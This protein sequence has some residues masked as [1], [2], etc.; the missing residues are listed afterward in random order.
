MREPTG[1][2]DGV[3]QAGDAAACERIARDWMVRLGAGSVTIADLEDFK[4]WAT[5]RP[6]HAIAF[7]RVRDVW[8][9][10]RIAGRRVAAADQ[11][12]G[13]V[14]G[15]DHAAFLQRRMLIGGALAT[16]AAA[17][18]V[19]VRPPFG[20]WTPLP[21]LM[22]A[23]FRTSTG[24]RRTI[25]LADDVSIELNTRTSIAVAH[26]HQIELLSGE[27]AIV[28][29]ARGFEVI[30]GRGRVRSSSASFCVRRDLDEVRITCIAGDVSVV[31]RQQAVPL[32]ARQQVSYSDA[33]LERV[34][35]VELETVTAWRTG[36]L[37]FEGRPLSE[38]VAEA[39]RYRRGRIV[40]LN[41]ALGQRL[42]SA[43]VRI[44]QIDDLVPK[45][46]NS[47]GATATTLPGGLVIL[48]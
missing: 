33:G 46:T 5:E 48:S 6:A 37:V 17:V 15:R 24:E 1:D 38:V 21:E 23:D 41:A 14:Q 19:A 4:R 44:D 39:N 27:S 31:S 32:T 45:L 40:I 7:A 9:A 11:A 3:A 13:T 42:I 16:S 47:F 10:S 2:I 12:T 36:Y 29:G 18:C 30:A 26:D 34:V 35:A 20:L 43:R 22:R 8:E 28:S 25:A